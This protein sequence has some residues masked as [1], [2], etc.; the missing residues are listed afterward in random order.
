MQR[1][2][3]KS[4]WQRYSF[5]VLLLPFGTALALGVWAIMGTLFTR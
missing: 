1:D 2:P 5:D 4:F 3:Q